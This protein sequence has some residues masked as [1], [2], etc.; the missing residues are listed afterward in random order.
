ML[1]VRARRQ[2]PARLAQRGADRPV[3]CVELRVDDRAFTAQPRPV[4][5]VLAIALDREDRIDPVRLAQQEVVLAMVGRHVDKA[6]AAVGGDE[7]AGSSGR[8]LAKNPP[9][10]CIGWRA[11][12]PARSG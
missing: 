1:V 6:G 9:R 10:W 11:T 5:A 4:R 8:G 2:Q 12:V 3:G 7:I